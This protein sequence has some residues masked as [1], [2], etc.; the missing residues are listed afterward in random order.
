LRLSYF[1]ACPAELRGAI[2]FFSSRK[3]A[4]AQ[5][6]CGLL[7]LTSGG[8]CGFPTLRAI[9]F[10]YSRKGAE[11]QRNCGFLGL[12]SGG[13]CGFPTLQPAPQNCGEL[14]FFFFSQRRRD[15]PAVGRRKEI[16]VHLSALSSCLPVCLPEAFAALRLCA[17]YS[18]FFFLLAKPTVFGMDSTS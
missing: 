10:F 8:L 5:R 3:D 15:L 16:V 1:A 4:E 11:T 2:L 12:T 9:L 6:N 7:G 17:P 18:S 13:L 14:F